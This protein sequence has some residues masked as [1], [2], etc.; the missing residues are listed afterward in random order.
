MQVGNFT[1]TIKLNPHHGFFYYG[2]NSLTVRGCLYSY[3]NRLGDHN[4]E[5]EPLF[6]KIP[7][8]GKKYSGMNYPGKIFSESQ[9]SVY[10]KV[11]KYRIISN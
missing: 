4:D 6:R 9:N 10:F 2:P 3:V 1:Y 7:L 5:R 11:H 8:G